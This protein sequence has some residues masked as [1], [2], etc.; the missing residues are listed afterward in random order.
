MNDTPPKTLFRFIIHFLRP[1]RYGM[2]GLFVCAIISGLYGTVNA[3]LLKLLIDGMDNVGQTALDSNFWLKVAWLPAIFLVINYEIHNLSWR[4][5]NYINL[6]ISPLIRK[7]IVEQMFYYVH[8]HS[9]KFF[10]DNFSGTLASNISKM[11]DAIEEIVNNNAVFF[12]RGLVQLVNAL[13]AMYWVHP[14]FFVALLIWSIGFFAISLGFSNR[15]RE[16]SD[17][18]AKSNTQ[19]SGQ[20]NDSFSNA[21]NVRLFAREN[22]ET[23]FLEKSLNKVTKNFRNKEWYSLKLQWLQGVSITVLI[24]VMVSI[25]IHLRMRNQVTIG[26]FAMILGLV[27]FVTDNLWWLTEQVNRLNDSL[28]TCNQSLKMI[29]LPHDVIDTPDAKCLKV[30]EGKIIFND[31]YFKYKIDNNLFENKSVVIHGGQ[32]VGLVGFSGSGKTTFVNLIVRLFDLTSGEITIDGHKI[33]EITQNSL[34]ENIGFI[35]QDP[36]LFHRSLMENIR[37]GR[38]DATDEEVIAASKKAHAHEFILDTSKGYDSLVGERGIKLSGGQRQRISI[39][40]AIL[41]N[42]PILILDEATSALDSVT[43][44]YIQESLSELMKGKTVIVIAHRLSTLL[45]MDRILV[46]NEGRIVED[47]SHEVLLKQKGTYSVLWNSQV[48]G[49]L[50][51]KQPE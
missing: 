1:Y 35:T 11:S 16:L 2:Y 34:R 48:G 44:A 18:Y 28:G 42:A 33:S 50:L 22:Y 5:I 43:E 10:Q 15:V 36:V 31:V 24:G 29:T 47:G 6:K 23:K 4:S 32:K 49:F 25:L 7:E 39:A 14:I 38:V 8:K 51:D 3:Y 37:Y 20:I 45:H 13:I 26:D 19:L 27:T 30:K 46:F 40:R 41:K 17:D 9:F 21:S 12:L